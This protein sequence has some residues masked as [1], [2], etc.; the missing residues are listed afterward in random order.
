MKKVPIYGIEKF[1]LGQHEH[2]LYA[3][4]LRIHLEDHKFVN[5][6]HAHSTYVCVIFTQGTG[7]HVIDFTTYPVTQ[8]SVFLLNPGQVHCWS[9]SDDVEGYVFFHTKELYESVFLENKLEDFP[10]FHLGQNHPVIYLEHDQIRKIIPLFEEIIKE[11]RVTESHKNSKITSLINLVY[12]DLARVHQES[13]LVKTSTHYANLK[14]LQKLI[15]E[16]FKQ[17]KLPRDYAEMMNMTTRH[18][19]RICADTLNTTPTELIQERVLIEA[20]RMLIHSDATISYVAE[21]LGYE[22]YSYFIRLFKKKV[23]M[24]PKEFQKKTKSA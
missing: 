14:R 3:N 23:G 6:H 11:F 2:L 1:D 5:S 7:Q 15:D 21:A 13:D 22:D 19:S 24:S 18:L 8:G 20:K 4:D 10:F 17:K 16:Y 9:L 12:I